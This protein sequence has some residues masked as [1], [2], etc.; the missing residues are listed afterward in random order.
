M[1]DI[2]TNDYTWLVKSISISNALF[3]YVV[4]YEIK[5]YKWKIGSNVQEEDLQDKSN[6]DESFHIHSKRCR[7]TFSTMNFLAWLHSC[8]IS[9]MPNY[10]CKLT[11]KAQHFDSYWL[12]QKKAHSRKRENTNLIIRICVD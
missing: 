8:L 1:I 4:P 12:I 11:I 10:W 2:S 9:I 3:I 5:P 6:Y 7:L